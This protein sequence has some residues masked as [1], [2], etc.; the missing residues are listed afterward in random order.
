MGLTH[1]K[2]LKLKT[3]I[4]IVYSIHMRSKIKSFL[5]PVCTCLHANYLRLHPKTP[6]HSDILGTSWSNCDLCLH[7][8]CTTVCSHPTCK[9]VN[10]VHLCLPWEGINVVP[11]GWIFSQESCAAIVIWLSGHLN[12]IMTSLVEDYFSSWTKEIWLDRV[13]VQWFGGV[14]VSGTAR[15]FFAKLSLISSCRQAELSLKPIFPTQP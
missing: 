4:W 2:P 9:I 3:I 14:S 5:C 1:C 8:T 13:C 11:H 15:I 10:S 12:H 7:S 6:R